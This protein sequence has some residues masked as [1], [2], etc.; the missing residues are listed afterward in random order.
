MGNKTII[1]HME[2]LF[3]EFMVRLIKSCDIIYIT[4]LYFIFGIITG[5]NLDHYCSKLFGI[6]F[7][8]RSIYVLL[9]E[10]LFQ[11]SM[12]GIIVYIGRNT[13]IFIPS[14]LNNIYELDHSSVK[15]L[16]NA[17]I[18]GVFLMMF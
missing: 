18:L 16:I 6:D 17:P 11:T 5:Y 13:I 14:P 10:V 9:L 12:V 2:F 8:N 3:H 7:D 1:Q 4:C 15:E